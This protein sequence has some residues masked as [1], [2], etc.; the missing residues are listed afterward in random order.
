MSD[1][2]EHSALLGLALQP[3]QIAR[4]ACSAVVQRISP[5]LSSGQEQRNARVRAVGPGHCPELEFSMLRKLMLAGL[6]ATTLITAA[7]NTIAG[8]GRDVES[9][10]ETVT[11]VRSEERRVGKECVS[12]CRYRWSPYN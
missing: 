3:L 7:C 1:D 8:V 10:G 11:A 12:T 4:L 6:A 5:S 9:V 2:V